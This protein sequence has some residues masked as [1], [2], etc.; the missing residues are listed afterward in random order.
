VT[1]LP[2]DTSIRR[3][4]SDVLGEVARERVA[5]DEKWGGPTHDFIHSPADWNRYIRE[6]EVRAEQALAGEPIRDT[7]TW[8]RQMI[9][10]AALAV[11]AV[12]AY[13]GHFYEEY[14]RREQEGTTP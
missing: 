5:Q 4:T 12:E 11:A 6:H 13:D 8:R 1:R 3:E 7:D 9:R 10:V 2:R 14:Q